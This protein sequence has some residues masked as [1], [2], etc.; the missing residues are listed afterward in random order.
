MVDSTVGCVDIEGLSSRVE[1][2]GAP[3]HRLAVASKRLRHLFPRL[4]RRTS[5]QRVR[6][7]APDL[8]RPDAPTLPIVVAAGAGRSTEVRDRLQDHR[9]DDV[10][11]T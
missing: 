10:P 1:V 6:R 9:H 3:E 5:R 7:R 11:Q 2:G 8:E 4:S